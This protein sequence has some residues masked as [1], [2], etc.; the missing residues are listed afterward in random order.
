MLKE[1]KEDIL[2][3]DIKLGNRNGKIES[4]KKEPK[5]HSRFEKSIISEIFKSSISLAAV[6]RKEWVNLKLD[7]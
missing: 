1:I 3:M 4:L 6:W 2:K 7:Q 5:G